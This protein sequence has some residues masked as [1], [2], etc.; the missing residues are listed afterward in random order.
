MTID[1]K[2]IA[3][4]NLIFCYIPVFLFLGGW[5]RWEI[6]VP[7]CLLL[8]YMLYTVYRRCILPSPTQQITMRPKLLLY[9]ALFTLVMT[10][11]FFGQGGIFQY[12][13]D[14][15]K[16]SAVIQDLCR[17]S[18]PVIYSDAETPSILTYY[19]GSYLFPALVGKLFASRIVAEL[20]L[21]LVSWLAIMLLFMNILFLVDAQTEKQQIW[22]IVIYLGFYGLLIPLQTLFF[23][24]NEDVQWGY[25]HW[26]T[27]RGLAY[28][29]SMCDIKWV[30]EQYIIPALGLVMF[31]RFREQRRLYAVWALPALIC[32][33]WSFIAIL[34]YVVADYIFSSIQDRKFYW[35]VFSWQNIL[36]ALIGLV[37]VFYFA[38]SMSS[39][40]SDEV[41]FHFMTGWKFYLRDYIPFCLFMF[42]FYYWL[43][44]KHVEH[45]HFF[46][47]TLGILIV[48]PLFRAGYFND[49]CMYTSMLP[50]F[51]LNIYCIRFLLDPEV[52]KN[53]HKK[54]VTLIVCIAIESP[55]VLYE[56]FNPLQ[57]SGF[58]EHTMRIYS[59]KDCEEI[60]IDMRSNYFIYD[61]NESLFY[62]YI[63]RK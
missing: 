34:L 40:K 54:W 49:W 5:C 60:Q 44:W 37:M 62:K 27:V 59:C 58:P 9:M 33:T 4:S 1:F 41:T 21:G 32:G 53:V 57:Y 12:F 38:G 20:A 15:E 26:Y 10:M 19:V 22:A 6:A 16:H 11:V 7:G 24:I 35:D 28:R 52:K 43:I 63:A 42:A 56:F 8:G 31:Y 25:R 18:W 17:Y 51:M 30:W 46:Y 3:L 23:P 61:Y 2:K 39:E 55:F 50:L 45:D 36:C 29:A 14:Y 13:Y 47:I 48:I